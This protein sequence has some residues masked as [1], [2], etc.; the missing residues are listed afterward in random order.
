MSEERLNT[1]LRW[2][3]VRQ[4][5]TGLAGTVGAALYTR[6]ITQA[7]LGA[8]NIAFLVFSA[9]VLLVQA[10]IR[11]AIIYFQD[12]DS[13]LE[14]TNAALWILTTFSVASTA[15]VLLLAAPYAAL[16]DIPQAAALTRLMAVAFVFQSLA[17]VPSALLLKRFRYA[18]REIYLI[19]FSTVLLVGWGVMASNGYG[20][21][22]LV[23]PQIAAAAVYAAACWLTVGFVPR[24]PRRVAPFRAV[25][26]FSRSLFGSRLLTYLKFN[27]DNAA[28]GTLGASALGAYALGEDQSAFGQVGVGQPIAQ[29]ALPALA[30]VQGDRQAVRGLY[31]RMLR[32]AST[33]SAPLHVGAFVLAERG[34]LLI[35]GEQWLPAVP[36]LRAYLGFRLVDTLLE[37]TDAATSAVGRPD[38]RLRIDA[39]QLPF[40]VAAAVAAVLLNGTIGGVAWALAAVRLVAGVWYFATV[41]PVTALTLPDIVRFV[42]PSHAAALLMGVGVW[43]AEP[44]LSGGAPLVTL[45]A[46]IGVGAAVYPLVLLL[47]DRAG[48]L[49][50][51]HEGVD[52]LAPSW[53]KRL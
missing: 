24:L 46:L 29:I 27:V 8:F 47:I 40:F 33:V 45:L 13:Q 9:L 11:D 48:F 35:F 32:L 7:D 5:V 28:V 18:A 22:S 39:I 41:M 12:E 31:R 23:V 10:P 43:A 1:G 52:I 14:I 50:V 42:L 34:M 51:L 16:F 37:L 36:V 53:L 44:A 26:A 3:F 2:A 25:F 38:I 4:A 30:A 21:L 6:F 19:L 15:L 20:A 17:V 49:S